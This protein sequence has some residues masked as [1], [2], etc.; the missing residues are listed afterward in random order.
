MLKTTDA[1]LESDPRF[2]GMAR[3]DQSMGHCRP[4]RME[5][6]R[7]L[8]EPVTLIK[9]VPE[10]IRQQ[11]DIAQNAFVYSRFVYDFATLAEKQGFARL[12]EKAKKKSWL[13]AG[14]FDMPSVNGSGGTMPRLDLLLD[15]RNH[16]MHGSV[17]LLPQET[18]TMLGLCAEVINALFP[19]IAG[20]P[21]ER[22]GP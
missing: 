5:D 13:R 12:L 17:H 3:L 2:R 20:E 6:L 19:P 18:P 10:D 8:V 16:A 14:D 15:F 1:L 22:A 4:M 7:S 11:F 9:S 21:T